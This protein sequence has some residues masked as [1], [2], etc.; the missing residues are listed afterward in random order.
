LHGILDLLAQHFSHCQDAFPP[1]KDSMIFAL[2][3][4]LSVL[5]MGIIEEVLRLSKNI[6]DLL[7]IE[8]QAQL[9]D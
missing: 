1:K 2:K 3:I 9:V 7:R 6:T 5:W 8:V 4:T